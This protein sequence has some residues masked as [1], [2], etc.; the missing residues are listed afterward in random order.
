MK[1][2]GMTVCVLLVWVSA[3]WGTDT[4]PPQKF[5]T[6]SP[7]PHHSLA[8]TGGAGHA[9]SSG[10]SALLSKSQSDRER[11]VERLEHQNTTHLQ[12]QSRQRSAKPGGQGPRHAEPTGHGSGINYSYHSPRTQSTGSG[13]RKQ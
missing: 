4:K 11:E 2:V 1:N 3:S 5:R 13:G 12:T 6:G 7:H 8:Q 10:S 9:R